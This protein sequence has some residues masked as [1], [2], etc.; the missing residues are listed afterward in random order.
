[1]ASCITSYSSN[2]GCTFFPLW[3]E[4]SSCDTTPG[5]AIN[6]FVQ[7]CVDGQWLVGKNLVAANLDNPMVGAAKS[8]P[9]WDVST[10]SAYLGSSLTITS[11]GAILTFTSSNGT[12]TSVDITPAIMDALTPQSMST[13]GSILSVVDVL[14]N[15][16][17]QDLAMAVAASLVAQTVSLTGASL[18]ITDVLGTAVVTDLTPAI[19]AALNPLSMSLAGSILTVTD[20]LGNAVTQDIGVADVVTSMTLDATGIHYTDELGAV[21]NLPLTTALTVDVQDMS[22]NHLY[23]AHP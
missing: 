5:Y 20:V 21:T 17:T 4:S 13:A 3:E 12:S 9:T 22:G 19:T 14:G 8:P 18:A 1:M 10:L 15:T 6:E 16:A 23:Y 2:S 7:F 11:A